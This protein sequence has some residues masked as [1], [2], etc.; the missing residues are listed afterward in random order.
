MSSMAHSHP[1]H[2]HHHHKPHTH[3]HDQPGGHNAEHDHQFDLS[4]HHHDH[5]AQTS[6][7]RLMMALAVTGG[8]ALVEL[9]GGLW[10]NSLAL[11]S[12]AGHM[13][14]DT[15]ALGLALLA[16]YIGQRPADSRQSYGYTRAELIGAL[17][18]SLVM[19]ALVV[20]ICV[21]A[22]MRLR[23]PAQVNGM[24]VMVIAV[25][26]L[27]VNVVSA[28]ALS[29][30][31][32]NLN[33]RA[34]LMHVMGDLLGSV[35]AIAAGAVIWFT[36]W[37]PIDPILSIAV[38]LLILRSTW[39]ILRQSMHE[40]M[41]GVP[42]HLSLHDIGHTLAAEEGVLEVHDLHVWNLGRGRIAL[43][44]HLLIT[45]GEHWPALLLRLA[46]LLKQRYGIDHVTLQPDWAYSPSG[47][48]IIP[49]HPTGSAHPHE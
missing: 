15:A 41:D 36:G 7:Q 14:T 30:D 10:A 46:S 45:Q 1:P 5:S 49:I 33:S 3:P 11:I 20:W 31:H 23:E 24:G 21:E 8:F 9:F 16:N 44:A 22:V 18:N 2:A 32:D 42:S 39:Q 25:I 12:D 26:G 34:A 47:A 27:L 29:H 35:A 6:Q 4:H 17:I 43:S 13:M 28:W 19:M 40:L 37:L 38:S 48:R